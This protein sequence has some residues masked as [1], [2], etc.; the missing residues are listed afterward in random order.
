MAQYIYTPR[1]FLFSYHRGFHLRFHAA[2]EDGGLEWVQKKLT[3]FYFGYT[4]L[5]YLLLSAQHYILPIVFDML[6]VCRWQEV[7]FK[8]VLGR[9]E[10]RMH[11]VY[12]LKAYIT[13]Q[14]AVDVTRSRWQ[15]FGWPFIH[16]L[17][18]ES[19]S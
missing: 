17:Q 5:I 11:E 14:G 6:L 8:T 7:T 16:I 3:L 15:Y 4:F 19:L 18:F 10:H 1:F 13:R 12:T 2:S 9:A